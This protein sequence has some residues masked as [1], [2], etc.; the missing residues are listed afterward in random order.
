L[1]YIYNRALI[2][3]GFSEKIETAEVIHNMVLRP[4]DH[5]LFAPNK[6]GS[7]SNGFE[8]HKHIEEKLDKIG[9]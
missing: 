2:P 5:D 4:G 1:I 8:R 9:G 3:G 6:R 7:T